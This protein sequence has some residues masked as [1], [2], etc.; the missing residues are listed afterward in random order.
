MENSM[1]FILDIIISLTLIT[2]R[3]ARTWGSMMLQFKAKG[4]D[5]QSE[6]GNTVND[7]SWGVEEHTFGKAVGRRN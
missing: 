4:V 7:I 3:G 2:G 5:T 1:L 6:I